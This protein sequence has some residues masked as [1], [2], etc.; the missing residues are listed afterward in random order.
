MSQATLGEAPYRNSN[1]FTNYYLD[2]RV[3][4]LDQWNVDDEAE[5]AFERLRS[6]WKAESDLLGSYGEDELLDVWIDEVLDELGYATLSET[7]LPDGGGYT[8]RLLFDSREER[9][10]AARR[11]QNGETE[12]MFGSVAAVLEAKQWDASFTER[13]SEQRSYRDASHQIKHYLEHTPEATEWGILTNGQQW[14][15]YGTKDYATET[16]YEVNLPEIL[17]RGDLEAFKYFY[18]FFRP[19]AFA[20]AGGS[21][22][23]DTVWNESET[24]AQEL[25]E[26]L[27]DSVF[28]A[29]RVLA[30][31][32]VETNDLD[33]DPDDDER[34]AELK[35]QSLVYLYRLMFVLYAESRHLLDPEDP[36]KRAEYRENFGLNQLRRE[37]YES[38]SEGRAFD[39]FSHF[40]TSYWSRL[41][42]LFGL[43]DTGE[44][45]LGVPP[46][47][48]GLF[49]ADDHA[50]LANNEVADRY[51]AE[52]LY[53]IGTTEDTDGGDAL[54]DYADL[55]TRHLG[56][57]YEGLLE[58]KFRIAPEQYAA[59]AEDGGQVWQPATEVSVTDAV[60][61]VE[62][63]EL[64]VVNDDGERNATG[65][66]YTPDYVVTYIVEKTVDPLLAEI[67]EGLRTDGLEPSDREYFKR[68]WESV[69]DLTILD[70]AMGSG[71][72]L[73]KAT[74]YL[75]ERVMSVVRE[76]EIQG[77]DEQSLR[78]EIAK[79]CI[80]GV[81]VNGMAVELAK[82]SMWLETLAADKPLAFLNHHLKR[83]NSL[84]GSDI[85]EVLDEEDNT[86]G[87]GTQ[88]TLLDDFDKIRRNTL[89]HVRE[90]IGEL[91]SI[92]ND[93][94][95]DIKRMEGKYEEVRNDPHYRR[96]IEFTNVHTAEQFGLDVPGEAYRTMAGAIDSEDD[97]TS[98]VANEDW[99]ASAQIMAKEEQ[100]FHWE[101]EFPEVFV[102]RDNQSHLSGF[103]VIIGNPPY[104]KISNEEAQLADS[105]VSAD[106]YSQFISKSIDILGDERMLSFITPTSWE[107]G[108][109]YGG[110]RKKIIQSGHLQR[111][112]NLPYDVFEDA[113]VDTAIF[114][115]EKSSEGYTCEVADLS[116]TRLSPAIAVENHSLT[117]FELSDWREVGIVVTDK[118]WID[119]SDRLK[120]LR[121][122][123]DVTNSTRGVLVTEASKESDR[124]S[125]P[126]CLDS[127][128]RYE[129][130]SP[131]TNVEYKLL[132]E[133]PSNS[134]IF[135]SNR[136]LV[137]RL[138]SR[139]DRLLGTYAVE[140]FVSKKDVYIFKSQM[141]DERLLLSLVN[142]RLLSWWHFNVEM[143]A[144]KDDFRQVTLTGIR[145]LPIPSDGDIQSPIEEF[146]SL[147]IPD[148]ILENSGGSAPQISVGEALSQLVKHISQTLEKKQSI[149]ISLPDYFGKYRQD[150]PLTEL[151]F[152][153]PIE[154]ISETPITS[155]ENK[156]N[157][158]NISDMSVERLSEDSVCISLELRYKPEDAGRGEYES[159]GDYRA[160]E[161][162]DL[163]AV[164]RNLIE[165][166]IPYAANNASRMPNY[167]N[168]ATTNISPMQRVRDL[169]F[170]RVAD[171]EQGL[172]DY[173]E[174][175]A[176]ADELEE[177]IERTDELIDEI[178]YDLYGLTDEEIE[179]VE[180]SVGD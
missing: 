41:D 80:Y 24:A 119:M 65:A 70:P 61:T 139:S 78:R 155:T 110:T 50:F 52:V 84:V 67:D 173:R 49:D 88:T 19:T 87:D 16:Y 8:D 75:T 134:S 25:G 27:Q 145:E 161:V 62:A 165:T 38:V 91:E 108:P 111:L 174:A 4:S 46:Y 54:A 102:S 77:Y 86:D 126:I 15:L 162:R 163:S 36:D 154:N 10:E 170:P 104:A 167:R 114:V 159:L 120:R 97:W 31:G 177:E 73:T 128:Q 57:I 82:L 140:D 39:E 1:L 22:F 141:Y 74:G 151:G 130:L 123:S 68:Y 171:V 85:Y 132:K 29:L 11:R 160:L 81:D 92:D 3:Q 35:E 14:R 48:G 152:V 118:T 89:K 7:T 43:I 101:L 95:D 116:G 137:R 143:S 117:T 23:L 40:S 18:T 44:A 83:G 175:V 45:E 72:F 58:H 28:T 115:W 156:Y 144:S 69:L 125:T 112:I 136:L 153:Q 64:Y 164:E 122:L 178:V 127:Y 158:L 34:L 55:D 113:Y 172:A 60:E 149:N 9:A 56:S 21:T 166:F 150:R 59:V 26:D 131:T 103:D 12:A 106:L 20:D 142:S 157:K 37:V 5:V 30:E 47:N 129:Q 99:F 148:D 147:T 169:T 76:Q 96:L 79:E 93:E 51:L 180:E 176:R 109:D 124:A 121:T 6:L 107:T 168:N 100:F 13:F 63:G 42:D 71:H 90:L 105:S 2:N 179:I 17:E 32:F 98:E 133:I 146:S 135:E 66:Y 94:L 33:I 53:R 138:V